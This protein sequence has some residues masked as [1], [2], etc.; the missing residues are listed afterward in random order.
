[1]F[2][3]LGVAFPLPVAGPARQG[4]VNVRESNALETLYSAA[5]IRDSVKLTIA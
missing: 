5:A 1:M 4:F 2:V 3:E